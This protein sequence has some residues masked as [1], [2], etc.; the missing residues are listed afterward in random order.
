[1][2]LKADLTARLDA[3]ALVQKLLADLGG[4]AA[5]LAAITPPAGG[6]AIGGAV[7]GVA[8]ID[9]GPVGAAVSQVAALAAPL[10][11]GLPAA[12][13]VLAPLA[14]ALELAGQIGDGDLPGKI[15]S[16]AGKLSEELAGSREGGFVAVLSRL[17]E[18]LSSAPEGRALLDVLHTLTRAGGA[19]L[20]SAVQLIPDVVPALGGAVR[21][22]GGLMALESVLSESDRLTGLMAQQL[23]PT[24]VGAAIDAALAALGDGPGSLADLVAHLDASQP[25]GAAAVETAAAGI[26]AAGER[27]S[28]LRDQLAGAM[29]FGEATLV[30]LDVDRVQAELET[31]AGMVRGADLDALE[32]VVRSAGA[33]VTPLLGLDLSGLPSFDLPG[34]LA[35][36]E[37]KVAGV[38]ARIRAFD[39]ASLAA[40]LAQG[41]GTVTGVIRAL[42]DALDRVTAALRGALEQI[43]QAVAS[44]PFDAVASAIRGVVEPVTAVLDAIRQLL[45]G[46]ESTLHGAVTATT[47]ALTDVEN[48]VAGFKANVEKLFGDAKTFVEKIHIDAAVGQVADGIKAFDAVLAQAQMQPYFDTAVAAIGTA[49]DVLTAVPFALLPDAMKSQVEAAVEP[50]RT[51]DAGAVQVSIEQLLEI[52]DG[53]FQLRPLLETAIAGVQ[54]SYQELLKAIAA[55]DPHQLIVPIDAQLDQ[56]AAKVHELA[57]QLTLKPVQDAI[58]Q[59]K[60]TVAGLDL[61]RQLAPADTVFAEILHALDAFSPDQLIAPLDAKLKDA[62]DKVVAAVRLPEWKPAIDSVAAQAN[63]LLGRFDPVALEP[64][65]RSAIAEARGLLDGLQGANLA[66]GFGGIFALLLSGSGL[67]IY[68]W[69]FEVVVGWLG[70]GAGASDLLARSGRIAGAVAQTRDAV[71]AL[72]LTATSSQLAA[73]V[74]ALQAAVAGLPDGSPAR[75]RLQAASGGL[76]VTAALGPLAA[77][78]DRYLAALTRSASL[79]ETLRRIGLSEVDVSILRLRAA[80]VPLR[81]VSDLLRAVA[82]RLGLPGLEHGLAPALSGLLDV[83]TPERL[84]ALVM[85]LFTAL[86]DRVGALVQAVVAPLEAGVD[87]IARL[88]AEIDLGPLR[89]SAGAVYQAARQQIESLQPSR[90]LAAPLA[91]FDALRAE[92]AGFDPLAD[93]LAMVNALRAT[94]ERILGK[95]HAEQILASPLAIYDHIL[96]ELG[97]LDVTALVTPVLDELDAIAGQ[98]DSGLTRTVAA[99]QRLQQSLPSPDGGGG[100]ALGAAAGALGGALGGAGVSVS[101][102]F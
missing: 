94:I 15:R 70:A 74:Q 96:G 78:R 50:I 17:A 10:L 54:A 47:Q 73:R 24:A 83:A 13:D 63:A 98:V 86:H 36:L 64:G 88:A 100:G 80:F 43:R 46:I 91:S 77:N 51:A 55:V 76:D 12:G 45:A 6:A 23:D 67:R 71:A 87:E 89:S 34:L 102:G 57:P 52:T 32:R 2:P 90:L 66:G 19:G 44:L 53:K 21:A 38:A 72:D 95:L 93:L 28:A 27:L 40:P 84:T 7:S 37:G 41:L 60:A 8:D 97:K 9:A 35:A 101:I 11:A 99:F 85:P 58:D 59:V 31:A 42:A 81:P 56:L 14:G 29:G 26:A 4:P 79:G 62:R 1:V 33:L 65:L 69:T 49:A 48:V 22:V 16:L 82:A 25:A 92:V 61:R 68:P 3:G 75:L 18:T 39:A 30:H 5:S 20:P